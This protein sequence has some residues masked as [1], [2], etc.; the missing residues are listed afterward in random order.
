VPIEGVAVSADNGG[1]QGTTDVNGYYE[2][3]VD[4]NWSGTVT[5]SKQNYTFEPNLMSYV[6]VLADQPDQNSV[7][8]NIYDLDYDCYI[9]WGDVRVMA[10]NWLQTGVNIP[11]DFYKDDDNTVNFLDFAKFA[12][13][14]NQ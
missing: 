9:G 6:G 12:E 8:H 4:Y 3:W 2:T 11:G 5:P 1:G 10:D 7:A 13:N 14:W